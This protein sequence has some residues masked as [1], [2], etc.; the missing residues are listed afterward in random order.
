MGRLWMAEVVWSEEE[1]VEERLHLTHR[2]QRLGHNQNFCR[3]LCRLH[4]WIS[5]ILC[6]SYEPPR[7]SLPGGQ[8]LVEQTSNLP[9]PTHPLQTLPR[10]SR[11]PAFQPAR[12]SAAAGRPRLSSSLQPRRTRRIESSA[13]IAA[14]AE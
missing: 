9:L 12:Q 1:A 5:L 6:S 3:N 7:H 4:V 8:V 13:C 11:L 14:R 10:G 2:L